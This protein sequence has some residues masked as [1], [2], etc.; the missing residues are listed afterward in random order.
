MKWLKQIRAQTIAIWKTSLKLAEIQPVP[1]IWEWAEKRRRMGKN[2]TAKPGRYSVATAPYQREPQEALTDP[3]VQTTVLY[4]A[5]RLG[6]TEIIN[7]LHGWVIEHTPRNILVVYPTLDSAKKWSKQFFMPMVR[8]TKS[9]VE[10]LGKNKSRDA[11]N[12]ILAKEYPGGV[13]SAI[14]SNSPSGF[15]QVQAPV[16]TCDEIDAMEETLEGDPVE[17]AFARAENYSDNIQVVS[18]TATKIIPPKKTVDSEG[19]SVGTGSRIHDFWLTSDQ[20]KWFVPCPDCGGHQVLDDDPDFSNQKLNNLKWPIVEISKGVWEHRIEE[21]YYECPACHSHW[22]DAKMLSAILAGEWRATAKFNGI[23]GY[24]LSGFNTVFPPKKGFKTKLHQFASEF[25]TACRKGEQAQLVWLNTFLCKPKV[26]AAET[27]ESS[28]LLERCETYTK[29]TLP[30]QIVLVIVAIDVQGNRVELEVVGVGD[31][32][33]T[34]GIEFKKIYG[35]PE[36][37][38][39]WEE[40]KTFLGTK[41]RRADGTELRITTTVIDL[42]FKPSKVRKFIKTCGIPALMPARAGIG[43]VYGT[44][45]KQTVLVYPKQHK[46]YRSFSYSVNTDIAKETIFARLKMTTMGANYMHWNQS[47]EKDYFDGLTAEAKKVRYNKGR[48]EIYFEKIRARN[49]PLDLRVYFLAAM[50]ILKPNIEA[51]R[52]SLVKPAEQRDYTLKEAEQKPTETKTK[53][54]IVASRH[55]GFVKGWKR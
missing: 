46:L 14:G 5:K 26:E 32:E 2:V 18:S 11:S 40:L 50:D 22:N 30:N 54:P 1:K 23:R 10:R 25:L 13:I 21:A 8:S 20:R 38:E 55:G 28:P 27:V 44:S 3:E 33:E 4:W 48:P 42:G 15:R 53:K 34:W 45:G 31:N 41:Y 47:Y 19:E 49:E 39:I 9:L 51:I 24:W 29:D 35:D 12:T 7:N 36:Q 43:G 16:V 6:K 37:K 17:L 52:K